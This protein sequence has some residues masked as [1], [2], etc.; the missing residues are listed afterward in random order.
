MKS[1]ISC[2]DGISYD[3][4]ELAKAI[5]EKDKELAEEV[6][7]ACGCLYSV[8]DKLLA[9]K[10]IQSSDMIQKWLEDQ[11]FWHAAAINWFEQQEAKGEL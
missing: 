8:M 1:L 4:G 7:V 2:I 3:L 10:E 6:W 9:N 11:D 5:E